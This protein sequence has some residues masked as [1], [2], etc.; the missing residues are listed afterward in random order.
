MHQKCQLTLVCL[1]LGLLPA[2]GFISNQSIYEGVRGQEKAKTTGM[3]QK[4]AAL[5]N[6]DQYEKEREDLKKSNATTKTLDSK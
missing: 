6:Y 3:T 5:P 2:C 1:A 4:P